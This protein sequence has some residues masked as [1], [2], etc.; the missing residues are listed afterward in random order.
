MI[1][2]AACIGSGVIG[3]GWVARLI[4][5][6]MDVAIYDPA[7]DAS[8]KLNRLLENAD[9]AYAKLTMAARPAKGQVTF[10][11]SI[12][13]AVEGAG[14]IVE[15]VPERLE[16]KRKVYAEI[17][18]SAGTE[19]IIA[20]ST[21]G[22]LPTELQ[23]DMR[24]PE[25]LLVAHPF[26][27]VYLLP[28][29]EVVGGEK[30][31]QQFICKAMDFLSSIGMKPVYIRK[32]IE[33]FV[34]DRLLEAVWRESLWLIRDGIC[35]TEELDEIVRNGFGLRWAQMGVFDT[36]RV[37]GGEAGMRHFLEQFGPCL[38][39]PWTRL[40]DVPE[41]NDELVDLIA[42]QSDSQSGH[43]AIQEMEQ[44]R[45]DNLVAIQQALK[46]NDWG[47]GTVLAEYEKK[48]FDSGAKKTEGVDFSRPVVTMERRIPPDWT[49]YNNHMNEARYLQCFGD[50]TD[51]FMRMMGVDADYIA[52]GNSL[53]TVETHIRHL[54]EVSVNEPVYTL[55]QLIDGSGKKMHVFHWLYHKDGTLLA[56][57]EHLLLHV[58]LE[59]RSTCEPLPEV[60][61]RLD[62]VAAHHSKLPLPEGLGRFVGQPKEN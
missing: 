27:P 51:A 31:G 20:S 22:L 2:N 13:E 50:A 40:T 62:E 41:F 4:E 49:D 39:W 14:W 60:R 38:Q 55:T 54:N 10:A 46:A 6:S 9:R 11:A 58:S 48:L 30:T 42:G 23:A 8:D 26:N 57:G 15:S 17:E 25:R 21:S 52:S 35:T 36:Y 5:N 59:T 61:A 12:A 45:D 18:D 53:F 43:L 19:A 7:P 28:A 29:V 3:G 34:A 33:A 56:T 24:H 37:A 32:E 47:A 16:L 1:T 44:V